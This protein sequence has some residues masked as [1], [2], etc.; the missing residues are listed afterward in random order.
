[1]DRSVGRHLVP[2]ALREIHTLWDVYGP[3]REQSLGDEEWIAVAARSGWVCI[4]RD[5]LRLH[6]ETIRRSGA[7]IFRIGRG[8]RTA[9]QQI[10]W[11]RRNVHRIVRASKRP[12][13]YIY[14]IRENS[15]DKVFPLPADTEE[16]ATRP[17]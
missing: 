14:V 1:M 16:R 15:V 6:R 4:T 9:A 13:P 12:G 8:A 5:E 7:R 3:D 10:E 11:I 17:R 2:S